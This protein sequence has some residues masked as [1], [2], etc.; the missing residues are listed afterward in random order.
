[1]SNITDWQKQWDAIP[2]SKA[3]VEQVKDWSRFKPQSEV[4]E[5]PTNYWK[6]TCIAILLGI[7]IA[8]ILSTL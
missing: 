2:D 3:T 1:M 5:T 8:M 7:V 4:E 6:Y